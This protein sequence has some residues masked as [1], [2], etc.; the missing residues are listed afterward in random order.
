[1]VTSACRLITTGASEAVAVGAPGKGRIWTADMVVGE[2]VLV[3]G[4]AM[5]EGE[6]VEECHEADAAMF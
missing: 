3:G 5:Y 6:R 2:G 1:M 4:G